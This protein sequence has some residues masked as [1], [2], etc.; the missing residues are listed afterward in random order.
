M[1]SPRSSFGRA[2]LSMSYSTWISPGYDGS[3]AIEVFNAGPNPVKLRAGTRVL[4]AVFMQLSDKAE[5]SY[6]GKYQSETENMGSRLREDF[7]WK[8]QRDD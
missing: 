2:G 7:P 8:G 1:L 5:I 6:I 3:I 4:Q